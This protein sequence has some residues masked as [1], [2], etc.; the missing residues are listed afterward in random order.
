M[1]MTGAEP[2]VYSSE[3]FRALEAGVLRSARHVVPLVM[4]IVRNPQSVVDVGCGLGGW[5][6]VFQEYGVPDVLGIDGEYVDRRSLQIRPDQFRAQDLESSAPLAD[7]Q[8]DLV[9]C[10]EVAEHLS[11][12][13]ASGFVRRLTALGDVVLFSAAIPG[14]GGTNHV[15]EQWPSYWEQL[16]NEA[17]FIVVDALRPLIWA[18]EAVEPW[19]AQNILLFVR[20]GL[21][22]LVDLDQ[23]ASR[24]TALSLVHPWFFA[25]ARS[26]ETEARSAAHSA[27]RAAAD[28]KRAAADAKR[29]AERYRTEAERY[30]R[31]ATWLADTRHHSARRV[32]SALPVVVGRAIKRRLGM[33]APG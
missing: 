21:T 16:F 12:A 3:F 13:T 29:E 4:R 24:G 27:E 1:L 2:V 23:S 11:V 7:R 9:V 8:F 10:L 26:G 33:R 22:N 31:E 28:A 32:L 5:L 17:G 6:H 20:A 19:Y 15:N 18:D 30:R 14:Q 25:Y